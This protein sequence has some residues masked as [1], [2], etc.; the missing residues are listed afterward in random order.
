MSLKYI[1][2]FLTI[3]GLI[4]CSYK[5]NFQYC[6][7]AFFVFIGRSTKGEYKKD[8]NSVKKENEE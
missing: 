6:Y 5:I 3:Y 4:N 1:I 7:S 8:Q 2:G